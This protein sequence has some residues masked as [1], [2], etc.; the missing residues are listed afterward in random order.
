MKKFTLI[1]VAILTFAISLAAQTT[2]DISGVLQKC[3]D[4]PDLQQFY[5]ADNNGNLKQ[6]FILQH[7]VSFPS[8]ITVTI[9]QNKVKLVDKTQVAEGNISSYFLFWEFTI[10]Q[11][12]AK[13]DFV[14]NFKDSENNSQ[15]YHVKVQMKNTTGSWEIAELN[16]DRR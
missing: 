13:A 6:L 12:S 3:I 16:T 9:G 11:N 8:A 4:L 14:Y 2:G 10:N 7:G 1:F 15:V 5:P